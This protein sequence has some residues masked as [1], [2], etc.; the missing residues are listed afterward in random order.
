M[1]KLISRLIWVIAALTVLTA[2]N[3]GFTLIHL[4]WLPY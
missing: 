4:G 2:L 3:L 1:E